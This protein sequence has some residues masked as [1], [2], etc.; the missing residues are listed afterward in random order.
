M[1]FRWIGGIMPHYLRCTFAGVV[2][3]LIV[4]VPLAYVSWRTTHYRNF[5]VVREGVLY[6]SGQLP[7]HGLKRLIHD[8]GIKT[9]VTLRFSADKTSEPPDIEEER[10]CRQEQL[11]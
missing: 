3:G 9:V 2:L 11:H 5:H 8:H 1:A 6:R 4:G 7:I 10:F